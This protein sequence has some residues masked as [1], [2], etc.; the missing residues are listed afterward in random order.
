MRKTNSAILVFVLLTTTTL[1]AQTPAAPNG[2]DVASIKPSDPSSQGTHVGVAPGGVFNAKNATLKLL[3]GQ[4]WDLRD[5][6][7]SGGPGWIDTDHYD[8]MA[9]SPDLNITDDEVR[10]M[11]DEQRNSLQ[12]KLRGNLRLLIEERFQLHSHRETRDLPLYTLTIAKSGS[13]LQ[14]PASSDLTLTSLRVRRTDTGLT[15]IAGTN[16]PLENL[17]KSLAGQLNRTVLD[18][19]GMAARY[20]FRVS[21]T[22][23]LEAAPQSDTTGPSLF[24]ALEEQLGLRLESKKGPVEVLVIDSAQKP[25]AN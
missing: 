6:Q 7:I 24:T 12:N 14:Q 25:S 20:D 10:K 11:T 3:I 5:F 15:E 17:V 2:F 18:Q 16:T 21:F 22:P 19:T 1:L 13:K 8:I 23:N 9:K 4:A